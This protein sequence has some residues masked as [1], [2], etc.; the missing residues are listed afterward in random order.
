L[1]KE[2]FEAVSEEKI[3]GD[4]VSSFIYELESY[5][6]EYYKCFRS[7]RDTG[8]MRFVHVVRPNELGDYPIYN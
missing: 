7:W 8:Q 3:I 5:Q 2:L 4:S 1:A 6:P